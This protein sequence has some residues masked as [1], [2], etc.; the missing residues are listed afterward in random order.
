[1]RKTKHDLS[2]NSGKINLPELRR[3]I[4]LACKN[5]R[6]LVEGSLSTIQHNLIHGV[7][8]N[9]VSEAYKLAEFSSDY[10]NALDTYQFLSELDD[11]ENIIIEKEG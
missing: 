6:W 3:S 11:R 9:I 7:N 10:A 5:A 8:S 4:G 1:M 2:Y